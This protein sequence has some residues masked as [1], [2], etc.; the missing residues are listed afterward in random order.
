MTFCEVIKLGHYTNVFG[1][2]IALSLAGKSGGRRDLRFFPLSPF[3]LHPG[4]QA[5]AWEPLAKFPL[6][7]KFAQFWE[8]VHKIERSQAEFGA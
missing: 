3:S 6:A 1:A 5:P 2:I 7:E 4:S 8:V